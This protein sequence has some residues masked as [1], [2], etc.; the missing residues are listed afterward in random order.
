MPKPLGKPMQIGYFM[1]ANHASNLVRCRSH[2]GI[3]IFVMN[4]PVLWLS[5]QQNTVES[6][7]FGS[8]FVAL[9]QARDMIVAQCYKL[10]MFGVPIQGPADG[11][12]DNQGG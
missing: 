1:D 5:E 12:C 10:Q 4:A 6:S 3:L 9:Q 2:S 11:F 8:E 7:T